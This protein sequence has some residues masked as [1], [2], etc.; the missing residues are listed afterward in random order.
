VAWQRNHTTF[1]LSQAE[2]YI[3]I[4]QDDVPSSCYW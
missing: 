2:K 4:T 3:S 1:T